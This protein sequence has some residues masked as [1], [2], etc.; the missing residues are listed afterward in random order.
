MEKQV[1][2]MTSSIFFQISNI[3]IINYNKWCYIFWLPRFPHMK[4]LKGLEIV[5]IPKEGESQKS[6]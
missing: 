2:N 1:E 3:K 6:L 4:H 5:E